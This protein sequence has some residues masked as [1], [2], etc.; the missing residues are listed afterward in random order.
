MKAPGSGRRTVVVGGGLA[1]MAATLRLAAAGCEVTLLE[2]RPFL[3]GR[4]FSFRDPGTGAVIDN[5]QHVLVGACHRLRAFLS[6]IGSPAGAFARQRA[7]AVPI[8]DGRGRRS[9][10]SAVRLPSPFHLLPALLRYRHL[11]PRDRLRVARDAGALA[12]IEDRSA[13]E[14]VPLGEWLNRRGTSREAIERFWE[15]LVT[16]ALNVPISEANLPLTAF[17]FERALWSGAAGGALWLPRT[18]LSEAIGEPGRRALEAAGVTVR[19]GERV[20]AVAVEG[21]RALGVELSGGE[22]L[23]ADAVVCALPPRELDAALQRGPGYAAVGTAPIVNA[24]LWYDRQVADL[25]FAGTFGS[26]LQWI[27][28]RERLLGPERSGGP[29]L[30]I[31]L[32]AADDWIDLPKDEIAGRLD[33]AVRSVFPR[34]RGARL[35]ASAVVKEPRATF[36]ADA[37][38]AHR[39]PG[40]RGPVDGLWLAGD[41]TDTG[42]PATM[43]GAVRSGERAAAA[44]LAGLEEPSGP[45]AR[46]PGP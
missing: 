20:T 25:A 22:T 32:S 27:F 11:G 17:F 10:L 37:G 9:T 33:E 45:V 12:R 36:R 38:C 30:G 24:Y 34:R 13:L 16:P 7:L 44:A 40:P 19:V 42:W 35:E 23:T 2:R 3:G 41:W 8:L 31:S 4:A 29:C 1:G 46:E 18:G 39:R 5:G 14:D 6:A 15:P 28:D 26:P 21:H 43:E